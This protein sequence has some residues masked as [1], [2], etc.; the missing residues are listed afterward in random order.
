MTRRTLAAT[1]ALLALAGSALAYPIDGRERTG[2]RR[3]TGTANEQV[4]PVKKHLQPG[5]LLNTAEIKLN[6]AGTPA[7][8]WDYAAEDPVLEA[9]L[10]SIFVG[11]D[12]SYGV[13]V[14]DITDPSAIAWAERKGDMR[15]Y[16]GSVGKVLCLTAL[17]DG[18][19]RAF[20]NTADRERVLRDTVVVADAWVTG[21][22]HKVPVFDESTGFSRW[23]AVQAGDKFT[24]SEWVDHAISASANSAG[25]AIWKEAMLLRQFGAEYPVSKERADEFLAK[26]PKQQLHDLSV[27][28]IEEPLKAAGLDTSQLKQGTFWTRGGQSRVPGSES[29]GTPHELAHLL[30]RIEQ[31]RLVDEW[32]SLEMKRYMYITKK[33]YRYCYAP[34]LN[35]AAVFFKSGS[36]YAC[37]KEEGFSC[38][39]YKGNLKNFMN[40]IAIIE[41][42]A[43]PKE[44][45]A[46]KRYIVAMLSNVLRVN[47]AW[48]HSRVGAAIEQA[49]RT[50]SATQ[51]KDAGTAA[52]I[53]DAGKGD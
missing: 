48:D 30:L 26:T 11:R 53:S 28:I 29:F 45:V 12:P 1:L 42:P 39:K 31:G 2:I 23:R 25:S 35:D 9:A 6:L 5:A 52:A 38:G 20:P 24:L 46:T 4:S 8:T 37:Q 49:V 44:G 34:E 19:R 32:S 18:L 43:R 41:S 51:V 14:I 17:M 33:R 27:Q 15:Q 3:L 47:S 16:P 22:S 50:R 36:L 10:D 13:T 7:A 40:S 21:D